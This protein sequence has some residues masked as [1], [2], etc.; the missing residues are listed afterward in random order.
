M[1][2]LMISYVINVFIMALACWAFIE[3]YYGIIE[4]SNIIEAKKVPFEVSLNITP[5]LF[6]LVIGIVMT[7][8]YK[9]QKKKHKVL[10]YLMYPLL[11][12]LE[13]ERE[14]LITERACR[15]AFVSLWYVLIF[16][17][18]F[19]VLSPIFSIYIPGYPLY[20]LFIVFFIQMTVFYLSLYRNKL[21]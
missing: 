21:M 19:L 10:S 7:V 16:A 18:G 4:L 15:T 17:A 5:V 11:F 8:F 1:N 9:M 14:K 20:I 2:R 12:P 6:L 13:D 3:F